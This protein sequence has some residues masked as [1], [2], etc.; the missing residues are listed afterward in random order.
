MTDHVI[1][2]ECITELDAA[3]ALQTDE[4]GLLSKWLE[5]VGIMLKH[6]VAYKRILHVA[7]L[8]CH[9]SNRGG[10]GLNQHNVPNLSPH[11]Y[12]G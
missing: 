11:S 9:P 4:L 7:E 1:P 5:C 6:G 12:L 2:A 10:L 3:L 8:F